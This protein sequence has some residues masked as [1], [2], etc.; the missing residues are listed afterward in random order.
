MNDVQLISVDDIKEITSISKAIEPALLDP[1]ILIGEEFYCY[2]ILGDAL[3]SELK[4]QITG[5]SLTVFNQRLLGVYIKPVAAYGAWVEASPFLSYKTV[6]KGVVK[7]SSDNSDNVSIE[8]LAFYRQS[9]KDKVRFF[10]DRLTKY[11][12]ENKTSYPLYR[13]TCCIPDQNYSNG[14]YLGD[15]N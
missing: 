11:L 10:Q 15:S 5:N 9:L 12:E 14:I 13:A 6:Q 7:Q 2:S 3:V 4:N 8:E 1:Y